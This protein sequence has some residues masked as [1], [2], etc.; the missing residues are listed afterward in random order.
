MTCTK[1]IYKFKVQYTI[2]EE[3]AKKKLFREKLLYHKYKVRKRG[4]YIKVD[5][6]KSR[7]NII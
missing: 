4:L 6:E 3:I 2:T 5:H 7:K 1:T